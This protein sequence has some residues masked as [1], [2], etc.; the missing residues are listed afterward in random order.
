MLAPQEILP[1]AQEVAQ[2]VFGRQFSEFVMLDCYKDESIPQDYVWRV[3]AYFGQNGAIDMLFNARTGQDVYCLDGT[4]RRITPQDVR[5]MNQRA[6]PAWNAY[7]PVTPPGYTAKLPAAP[8]ENEPWPG[9]TQA[10]LELYQTLK[11]ETLAFIAANKSDPEIDKARAFATEKG[12]LGDAT[13]EDAWLLAREETGS[14]YGY[15][16]FSTYEI[17]LSGGEWLVLGGR[18]DTGFFQYSRSE[19]SQL[20]L[21]ELEIQRL[22]PFSLGGEEA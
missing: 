21:Y 4:E 5:D 9:Q 15:A 16:E 7:K 12:L 14:P 13:I 3:Y 18:N 10:E 22:Q 11:K 17:K 8:A 6:G 20:E 2:R 19:H 1:I